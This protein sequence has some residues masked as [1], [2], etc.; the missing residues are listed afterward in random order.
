MKNDL[1]NLGVLG[2]FGL[3]AYYLFNKKDDDSLK[4]SGGYIPSSNAPVNITIEAPTIYGEVPT[5]ETLVSSPTSNEITKKAVSSSS[6]SSSSKV[7]IYKGVSVPQ[8]KKESL[9]QKDKTEKVAFSVGFTPIQKVDTS[10]GKLSS[11][12]AVD[13]GATT[14][15]VLKEN[16]TKKSLS[17]YQKSNITN[18]VFGV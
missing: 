14:I 12:S 3:G 10:T 1:L 4:Y 5:T 2:A 13:I 16:A 11:M 8:T 18:N 17:T 6:S 15:N 9:V 7:D